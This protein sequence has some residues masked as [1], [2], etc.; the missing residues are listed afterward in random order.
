MYSLVSNKSLPQII[1]KWAYRIKLIICTTWIIWIIPCLFYSPVEYS[2][3][4]I[5]HP[6][7]LFKEIHCFNYSH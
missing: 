1:P 3:Y 2:P 7:D 6:R 4:G 5:D